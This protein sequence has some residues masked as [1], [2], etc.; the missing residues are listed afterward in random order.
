MIYKSILP[1]FEVQAQQKSNL[2]YRV[3]WEYKK[4]EWD[5][6]FK[7]EFEFYIPTGPTM[8]MEWEEE[9]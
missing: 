4:G 7:K 5:K 9:E 3:N 8:L 2:F 1:P 6:P